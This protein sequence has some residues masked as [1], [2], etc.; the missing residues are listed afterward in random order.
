MEWLAFGAG[1]MADRC[2]ENQLQVSAVQTPAGVL[3][4]P[5]MIRSTKLP[6]GTV[7]LPVA[8]HELPVVAEQVRSVLLVMLP[9]VPIRS[10]TV[11]VPPCSEKTLSAVAVQPVGTHVRTVFGVDSV[12]LPLELFT[13]K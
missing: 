4:A 2:E 6:A 7:S 5:L 1:K 12:V 3:F 11:I 13:E 8:E 10:V 9:G